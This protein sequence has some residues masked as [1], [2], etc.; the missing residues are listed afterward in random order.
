M[1]L[2]AAPADLP[3]TRRALHRVAEDVL[4]PRRVQATGN[5][6]A[7][8]VPDGGGVGTPAFPD[9]GWVRIRGTDLLV[10]APDG[11]VTTAPLTSLRAA[12]AAA[13]LDGAAALD[14]APLAIDPGAA[15]FLGE[16]FAF[17]AGALEALREDAGADASPIRLW[18]EHFDL[19]YEEGEEAAGRRAG[20]GLSPGD[21]D[22]PEPYA[23]VTPWAGP[24]GDPALWRATGFIG[25]QLAWAD[26]AAAADPQAAVL[27]F[28]RERRAALR[29]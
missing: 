3:R 29:A 21:E 22:H 14:D 10:G 2:P 7:L 8:T 18:P 23:Y 16:V 26:L 20:Y 19:A 28:W 9:G 15:A 11:T 6:I 4:S 1:P 24:V 12:G 5:E 27:A 13:G 17:A 25:A